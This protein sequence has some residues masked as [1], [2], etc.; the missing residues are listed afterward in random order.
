MNWVTSTMGPK[1]QITLPKQV[2]MMLGALEKG[3]IIGF[4]VDEKEK[5]VRPIVLA[6]GA[7]GATWN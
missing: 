6:D 4:L 3:Q 7:S 5:S 2:R 1:G